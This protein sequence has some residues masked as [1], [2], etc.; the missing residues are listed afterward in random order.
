MTRT[1]CWVRSRSTTCSIICCRTT[2]ARTCSRWTVDAA[3]RDWE[4]PREQADV[5]ATAGYPADVAQVFA[6]AGPRR[7]WADHRVHRALFRHRPLPAVA[8]HLGGRLDR[9]ER[10]R[11]QAALGPVSVHPA[12][13]G[14]F[15]AGRLRRA[16]DPA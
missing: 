11:G 1:T 16:P 12:Q 14:V 9:A 4:D 8:D 6:A 7:R 10:I 15:H 13:P 3:S 5:R 2:G